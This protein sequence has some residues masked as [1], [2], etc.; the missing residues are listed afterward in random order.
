M[1]M[2]EKIYTQRCTMV[3]LDLTK[4]EERFQAIF[5]LLFMLIIYFLLSCNYNVIVITL[6]VIM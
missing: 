4:A 2:S 3:I 1:H 5:F 6:Y